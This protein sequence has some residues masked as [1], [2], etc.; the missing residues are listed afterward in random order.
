MINTATLVN[1]LR[2]PMTA[3]DRLPATDRRT[4]V[5]E[6]LAACTRLLLLFV[7]TVVAILTDAN[8]ARGY[9]P[10]QV[11]TIATALAALLAN[12]RVISILRRLLS[13]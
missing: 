11:V 6:L 12:V 9:W 5:T 4:I 8:A 1:M 10:L 7:L 3:V 2:R 13:E